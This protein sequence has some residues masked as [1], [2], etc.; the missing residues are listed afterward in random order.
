LK[1]AISLQ[2]GQRIKLEKTGG[3]TLERLCLG[4]NWGAIEKKG[5]FGKKMVAVDLDASVAVYDSNK[6]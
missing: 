4:A 1:M 6:Q 2:K 3:G 5:L